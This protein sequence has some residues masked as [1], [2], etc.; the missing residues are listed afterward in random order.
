MVNAMLDILAK[1]LMLVLLLAWAIQQWSN[2]R[3]SRR[4]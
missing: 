1:L 3:R 2:D 4:P